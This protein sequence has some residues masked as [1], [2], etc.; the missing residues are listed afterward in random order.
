MSEQF[1]IPTYARQPV[2]FVR[3]EGVWLYDEQGKA[4]LDAVS[5]VAVCNLGHCHPAVVQAIREQSERLMHTSNLYR[6]PVQERLAERLCQLAG[7]DKVFFGN[8]GAEAN[9]AA[10]KLARLHARRRGVEKPVVLVMEGSFHGRTMATLSATANQKVQEGFGP[11]LEGF[12][13][14]PYDDLDA[15]RAAADDNVVAVLV[16]PVQGEGGVNAAS[17]GYLQGLRELCDQHGWLLMLDEIQTGNGRT[18]TYFA[19]QAERIRPDVLTTAKGLGNGFPIGACLVSGAASDLF[20]PGNHGSTF[21]GNPLGCAVALAVIDTLQ[22]GV[23]EQVRD[24]GETLRA[25]LREA[26][27]GLSLVQEVRG[28][29]MMVGIQLDRPCGELVDRARE[30]GLLINVTAGSVIRLLPPLIMSNAE[31]DQLVDTL[32]TVL[33][34]YANEQEAP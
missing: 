33:Q 30:A 6:I 21:G 3:G 19:C 25:R 22:S 1:L 23:L 31:R 2:A 14:L 8:S 4:Y 20:G 16:E 13:R 29:G 18:G 27:S 32:S 12:R 26:L 15:V 11:L 17:P 24:K 7:M 9:E 10:I 34:R 5:G 28:Q